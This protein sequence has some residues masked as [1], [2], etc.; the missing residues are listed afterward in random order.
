MVHSK[1]HEIHTFGDRR[2]YFVGDF[3]DYRGHCF[4][5]IFDTTSKQFREDAWV[6]VND[7]DKCITLSFCG[8]V[9]TII[10]EDRNLIWRYENLQ[11]HMPTASFQNKP[12][13]PAGDW[14]LYNPR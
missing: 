6:A 1:L 10:L 8:N 14:C 3:V 5:A 7:P 4:V 13:G 12:Y 2:F 9:D 11:S